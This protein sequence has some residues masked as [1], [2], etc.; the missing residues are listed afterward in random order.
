MKI[1]GLIFFYFSLE[2]F[3]LFH[4]NFLTIVF[5]STLIQLHVGICW[6]DISSELKYS[7]LEDGDA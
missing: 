4:N 3:L 7:V 6:I 5:I 2:Y 1:V